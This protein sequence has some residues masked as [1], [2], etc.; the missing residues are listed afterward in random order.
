M[1]SP[2]GEAK[3]GGRRDLIRFISFVIVFVGAVILLRSG[4][5][6][7]EWNPESLRTWFE[8]SGNLAPI[9]Y[10]T[11]FPILV[12]LWFPLT[13]LSLVAG[14]LFGL[15]AS[16]LLLLPASIVC[17]AL[18]YLISGWFL[19]ETV[20]K[21]LEK[22]NLL[23]FLDSFEEM[24]AWRLSFAFRFTPLSVGMQNYVLGVA[25]VPFLPYMVG[26]FLGTLP[27]LVPFVLA[28]TSA[29]STLG[30]SIAG[31]IIAWGVIILLANRWWRLQK[32]RSGTGAPDS[33]SGK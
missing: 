2:S 8:D 29:G 10:F 7:I 13:G 5:F 12:N 30:L 21:M 26:S 11:L 28:G 19:R 1:T 20:R 25:R 23:R 3:Q 17:H 14:M 27:W 4:L 33:P 18:G 16:L 31:G 32:E 9:L 15:K 22:L 24:S 6:G